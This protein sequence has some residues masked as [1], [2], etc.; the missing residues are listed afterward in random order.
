MNRNIKNIKE[1]ARTNFQT[2]TNMSITTANPA[3]DTLKLLRN[4][5][6][7]NDTPQQK[8]LKIVQTLRTQSNSDAVGCFLV[9]DDNRLELFAS[10]DK[11][12][13]LEHK[14]II[15]MGE[16]IIGETAENRRT[17]N[18]ADIKKHPLSKN[19]PQQFQDLH[20]TAII[21][22]IRRNRT[23]GILILQRSTLTEYSTTEIET[24]ETLAMVL[25]DIIT[26]EEIDNYKNSLIKKQGI[27]GNDRIKGI[28][29]SKGYGVGNV[30][31]HR[32]HQTVSKIFAEDKDAELSRLEFAYNKMNHDLDEK[33][34][35]TK[36]GIGEHVD[37]LDTYRM[38][39]KDKGWYKKLAININSGLTAEAAIE[40]A[41]EDMW[42]RLSATSD[43]YL[44]ER[45]HDLRD[46]SDRLQ[47][48]L[49]GDTS[50]D[51][52][53]AE[54]A[55]IIVVA[56][57]MGP[58]DLMDY[59][60]T[61]IRGLI[62][63][64]GTPTMHVAIVAKA[65]NIPVIA[66]VSGM[67]DNLKNGQQI[68]IDGNNGYIYTAPDK[69]ILAR[70][71]AKINEQKQ[72][73]QKL[74]ELKSL[75]TETLDKQKIGLYINV[76]LSF[77]LD[78]INSTNCD[79]VGL[80]RTEIPFMTSETMPDVEKQIT[81]YK[82]LF[83][84]AGDRRV[85]FRSLD[86]GSDK[87]LPYWSNIG[88]DNPAIGWRSIRITLDRRAI[89]RKQIRA[90]LRAAENKVL[91]IMFPMI[92]DLAEFEDAKETLLIELEKEKRKGIIG[93]KEVNVGLMIEVPALLFQLDEILPKT[94]FISIGTND[95]AQFTFACDRGNP[96]LS[97]RYDVLSAP[98][99]R[100][101][102]DIISKANKH[103]VYCSVCGEMASNPL[104]AMALLGLG[105]RHLSVSGSSYGRV[106][107]M[108]RSTN[109][110]NVNDYINNLLKSSQ[111]NLR[112]QLMA[113]AYD[114]G[115]EIY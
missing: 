99:L 96:R 23:V 44:K 85:T 37:I 66:K 10:T 89:L 16:G 24:L 13:E 41:Y 43:Q 75:P 11:Y 108:I 76:G 81:Y 36:L 45:L 52:I 65:L 78:Y 98:F 103:K 51:K 39:A 58:A 90:F 63:E 5:T 104:E 84:K 38:F 77:D 100:I 94:D 26:G 114:H 91:N 47:S 109:I 68:A 40:R 60:Y 46:I 28:S 62:I 111:K 49:N 112:P 31:I 29:L 64:E 95:L 9:I 30:I 4:I 54:G 110:E 80:Y 79:G 34:N 18:I 87:L 14:Y 48:Y 22:I 61:K 32:R 8:M 27:S 101:M 82:D 2:G 102:K 50:D 73:A 92:S 21:P 93:P 106:K 20:S 42:N 57:T 7:G 19:I 70:I 33:F 105:Y 56:Q 15:R 107:S 59:D 83:D 17:I 86:V 55:D 115:I 1:S 113:Y 72:L 35:S 69:I 88:E 71:Y 74:S 6:D 67:L 3:L 53:I 97:E 12:Q 25:S